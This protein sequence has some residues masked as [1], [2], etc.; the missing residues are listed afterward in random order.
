MNGPLAKHCT[1]E[2]DLPDDLLPDLP[3]GVLW[4]SV[5]LGFPAFKVV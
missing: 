4:I 3:K 1:P 5:G 2:L